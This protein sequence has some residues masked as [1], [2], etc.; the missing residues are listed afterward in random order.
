VLENETGPYLKPY[1]RI[2]LKWTEDF[3]VRLKA[4]KLLEEDISGTL[5]NP[6][7]H[8]DFLDMTPEA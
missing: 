8:G 3:N 5:H 2:N 4:I 1:I 6:G 7:L